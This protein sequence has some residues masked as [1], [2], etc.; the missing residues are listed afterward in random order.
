MARYSMG[1]RTSGTANA[2]FEIIAGAGSR[3]KLVELGIMI[4]AQTLTPIGL[5][6]P[7]AIGLVPTAPVT[8]LS[9]ADNS[10]IAVTSALAWGTPP[11]QPTYF[12]RRATLGLGSDEVV[13]QWMAPGS[14]ILLLPATSLVLWLFATGSVLDGW[15]VV[16][17]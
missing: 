7:A 12:Y 13:W 4:N 8:A 1:F 15:Y 17:Q 16:E 3:S 10:T 5:G 14:G 11:T 2:V 9:E 6:Y